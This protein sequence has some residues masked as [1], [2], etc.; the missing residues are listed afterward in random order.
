MQVRA[1]FSR[2]HASVAQQAEQH[3][4]KVKVGDSI[5]LTGSLMVMWPSG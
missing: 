1:L 5:S 3:S 2:H 4:C